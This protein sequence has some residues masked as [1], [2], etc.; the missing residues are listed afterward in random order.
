MRRDDFDEFAELLDG[1]YDLIGKT[2]QAKVVSATAKAL[3]FQALADYPL[4][5]VRKALSV[6]VK[7]GEFTPTPAA[8]IRI[9]EDA[10][11][12]DTRPGA[13]EAWAIALTS[14]DEN[15]T[16]V[17]TAECA[18][19]FAIARPVLD[20]SGPISGRKTF[21]EAYERLVAAARQASRPAVWSVHLGFDKTQHAL[22]L[23]RAVEKGRLSAPAVAGM[24]PPPD[25]LQE[26]PKG[27]QLLLGGPEVPELAPTEAEKARAQ[28][29][30]VRKLLMEGMVEKNRKL[31][32]AI[33]ARIETED[34]F[35]ANLNRRV[36]QHAD[37]IRMADGAQ[38]RRAED[39]RVKNAAD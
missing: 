22:V 21:L 1:V 30:E 38:L 19:A 4:P 17:W 39:A 31:E 26:M 25:R 29:A 9:I 24:L 3:F 7:R 14:R 5:V 33:D 10:A 35:R 23:A 34:Q 6:H 13:E 2:A 32:E 20:S 16:I 8:I 36:R 12:Q 11:A 37:Y 18:E 28:L 27:T 15:D